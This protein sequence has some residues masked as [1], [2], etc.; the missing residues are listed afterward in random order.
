MMIY[1]K[2]IAR[3]ATKLRSLFNNMP[4][5]GVFAQLMVFVH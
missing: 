3:V 5:E 1:N 2:K 4:N